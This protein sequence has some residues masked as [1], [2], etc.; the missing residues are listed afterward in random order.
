MQNEEVQ[1]CVML[2]LEAELC[3]CLSDMDV[4]L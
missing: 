1:L 3:C 4:T 2:C